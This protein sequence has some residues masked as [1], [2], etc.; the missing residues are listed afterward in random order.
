MAKKCQLQEQES[1]VFRELHHLP[2]GKVT[3]FWGVQA[4]ILR[5]E[6]ITVLIV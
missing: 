2:S 4:S 6:N 5:L 1:A 3:P